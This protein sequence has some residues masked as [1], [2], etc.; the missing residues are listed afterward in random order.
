MEQNL[1]YLQRG[2]SWSWHDVRMMAAGGAVSVDKDWRRPGVS[3]WPEEELTDEEERIISSQPEV[4]ILFTHDVPEFIDISKHMACR[5]RHFL[6]VDRESQQHRRRIQ[7]IVESVHPR[8]LCHGHY[9]LRYSDAVN[10]TWGRL[11][12]QGFDCDG[13]GS[14]SWG[15]LDLEQFK[16]RFTESR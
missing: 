9:H 15:I 14:D 5:G 6:K 11:H 2:F 1:F 13:S 7:R 16:Q 8:I 4:D 3:W 10:A 12:V